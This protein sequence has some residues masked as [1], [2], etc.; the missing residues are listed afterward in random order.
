MRTSWLA[1]AVLV[2][3]L[4]GGAAADEAV[5]QAGPRLAVEPASFDFGSLLLGKEV[6]KS[7]VVRNVGTEDLVIEEV[8]PTCGCT[9]VNKDFEKTLKPGAR[10]VVR[11]K[12]KTVST[13]RVEKAVLIRWNDPAHKPFELKLTANV[14]APP[15]ATGER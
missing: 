8:V 12:L 6:E 10:T 9:V 5:S 2:A 4:A 15:A 11:L 3:G 13:G 14:T 7:F 1:A